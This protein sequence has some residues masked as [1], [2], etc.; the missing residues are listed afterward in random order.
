M[1]NLWAFIDLV[2]TLNT[3][4]AIIIV[5]REN[6]IFPRHGPGYWYCYYYQLPGFC[7]T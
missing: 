5:F 3:I 6:E 2:I 1:V 4:A 7:C